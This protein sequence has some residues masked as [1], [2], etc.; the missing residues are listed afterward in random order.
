M[1]RVGILSG[2]RLSGALTAE[3]VNKFVFK[4]LLGNELSTP[5]LRTFG[6]YNSAGVQIHDKTM[7]YSWTLNLWTCVL[8][9]PD[10]WDPNGYWVVYDT[11]TSGI[12]T[13][14]PFRYKD[15]DKWNTDDLIPFGYYEDHVPLWIIYSSTI[16]GGT[17]ARM[18][19]FYEPPGTTL[20]F[21]QDPLELPG[22]HLD[23]N[24]IQFRMGYLWFRGIQGVGDTIYRRNGIRSSVPYKV[25]YGILNC[26]VRTKHFE[27]CDD[28]RIWAT[29]IL[30]FELHSLD[31]D[32]ARNGLFD[33]IVD[34]GL[35]T[36]EIDSTFEQS[37]WK[38]AN[39][40][41]NVYTYYRLEILDHNV[42][43]PG[44]GGGYA[45]TEVID[46]LNPGMPSTSLFRVSFGYQ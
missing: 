28:C 3:K 14:Y 12:E 40:P 17:L 19:A 2:M 22:P 9:N 13:Q 33:M 5:N 23:C 15:A 31:P 18:Q 46:L 32:M 38:P 37:D 10:D 30:D 27:D 43:V 36:L 6:V 25:T 20:P 29:G 39:Y 35:Q 16:T 7:S 21:C 4:L 8:N 45:A 44:V 11:L 1:P 26:Q 42:R 34:P 24:D 41:P